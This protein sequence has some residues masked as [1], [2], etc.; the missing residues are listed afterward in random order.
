MLIN[1]K[2]EVSMSNINNKYTMNPFLLTHISEHL[3]NLRA[4]YSKI[5]AFRIDFFYLKDSSLFLQRKNDYSCGD[6]YRLAEWSIDF[7]D[8]IGYVWVMEYTEEHGI[9][10]HAI[11]YANGHQH[12]NYFPLAQRIEQHWG[13]MTHQQGRI[14]DCSREAHSYIREGM[15]IHNHVNT[16][17]YS[18]LLYA[19]SYLAKEEQKRGLYCYGVSHVEQPS[20]RGRP[21]VNF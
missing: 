7:M 17:K 6:M 1:I 2:W 13:I 19:L 20:G 15:G 9:H 8:I 4:R 18:N 11:F 10:Y 3:E 5:L 14:Y 16:E 12:Q 21:R